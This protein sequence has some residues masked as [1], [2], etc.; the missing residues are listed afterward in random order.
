MAGKSDDRNAR[1]VR[2]SDEEPPPEDKSRRTNFRR[3][4][5]P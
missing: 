3:G 2:F 4:R 1:S 5:G